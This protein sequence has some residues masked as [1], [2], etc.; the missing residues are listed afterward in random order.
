MSVLVNL[1]A[2]GLLMLFFSG[3]KTHCNCLCYT[4]EKVNHLIDFLLL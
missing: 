1:P 4:Y 3:K 2:S